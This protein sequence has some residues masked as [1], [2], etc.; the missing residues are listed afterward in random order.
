MQRRRFRMPAVASFVAVCALACVLSGAAR[1]ARVGVLANSYQQQTATDFA[2]NIH[3]H[4]FTPVD[5]SASTFSL[6]SLVSNFDVLLVFEDS[7][8]P[9]ATA[10]GNVVAAYA[11]SGRA[12]V[13]GTF[14]DQDR[15]DA[16]AEFAPH[17]WGALES[18]DPNTTDGVGTAYAPRSLD[19]A[20]I[21]A[22][23]LTTGVTTLFASSFAGG[24]AAKPGTT[25]VA[26]W[27]QPNALGGRDPAIAYRITAGACVIHVAIA[28]QYPSIATA[29]TDF[30]GD[31]YKTWRN[32]FDFGAA[33]CAAG[34]GSLPGLAAIP[35]LSDGALALLALALALAAAL[36]LPGVRA[37][38]RR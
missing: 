18:L 15:S 21:V 24:N 23:P 7:T 25:V 35:T 31:F 16:S 36:S 26:Y 17:G 32:A 33:H 14:Y 4:T 30:G 28:P 37:R 38:T 13:L 11:Q 19:P 5:T 29:S 10:V 8:F 34:N 27:A 9:S 3:G 2:A 22:H 20:S 12:V 6:A 1:A